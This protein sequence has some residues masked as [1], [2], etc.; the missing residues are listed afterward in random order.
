[1]NR[2]NA[3]INFVVILAILIVLN[4]VSLN[5]FHRFD[6]SKEKIYTLSKSS[7]EIVGG[8][9]DNLIV[10][11]YFTKNLPN[12]Y[13]D[14]GRYVRDLLS[15]YQTY[16]HGHLKFDFISPNDEEM[17]K[18]EARMN[19][20]QPAQIQMLENDKMEVREVY[21]GLYFEYQGNNESIPL[22][23][24]KDGLENDIT[25]IIKRLSR[26]QMDRVALYT[27][28]D[29]EQTDHQS[30]RYLLGKNYD[31]S[32]TDLNTPIED[33][34]KTLVIAGVSDSLAIE[35]LYNIDQFVMKGGNLLVFQDRVSMDVQQGKAEEIHSNFFD[36]LEHWKIHIA[37]TLVVDENCG[38]IS[39]SQRQG[40][41]ITQVPVRYPLIPIV[42]TLSKENPIVKKLENLILLGA[43]E[44]DVEMD[45]TS[46]VNF[47]PLFTSSNRSGSMS[48]PNYGITFKRFQGQNLNAMLNKP[49][50]ILSGI[51]EGEFTSYFTYNNDIQRDGFIPKSTNNKIII[52]ADQ[53]F[54]NDKSAGKQPNN[55]NFVLNSTDYLNGDMSSL[56]I[57][58]RTLTLSELD[59]RK[60][61]LQNGANPAD[62]D[63]IEKR[64][65]VTSKALNI[66]L[67]SLLLIVFGF[68]YVLL[69]RKESDKIRRIYE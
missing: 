6:F 39:V 69:K 17:L 33:N 62:I 52:V 29:A 23:Q 57:R 16:S 40:P 1:M 66:V 67:P 45:S 65:K 28:P 12:Q 60:Y 19:K 27:D 25:G 32:I 59:V 2:K 34:V 41:F 61:L 13:A 18:N 36:L 20:I 9:E 5:I 22:I 21:M 53:D 68:I 31:I 55:L 8:L 44:I 15:D 10:K 46:A 42:N 49:F 7:K 30:I 56:E 48:G 51:F 35:Q 14:L 54:V 3:I 11:A 38:Q 37:P 50:R 43:S 64:T 24:V 4:L 58:S 63:T 47:T 26:A